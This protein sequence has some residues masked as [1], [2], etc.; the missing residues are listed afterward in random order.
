MSVRGTNGTPQL[1]QLSGIGPGGLLQRLGMEVVHDAPGVGSNLQ[2][3]LQ[4]R[5]AYKITGAKT[6]NV[7]TSSMWG[8]SEDRAGICAAQK[9]PYVDGAE[10]AG[11]IYLLGCARGVA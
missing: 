11:C 6:L 1:L 4:I 5:C 7:M 3:H 9:W 8:K 10:P 2:D